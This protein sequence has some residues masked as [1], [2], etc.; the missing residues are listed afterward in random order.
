MD[1]QRLDRWL[2]PQAQPHVQQ[3][4]AAIARA[5]ERWHDLVAQYDLMKREASG[6]AREALASLRRE[7]RSAAREL[8]VVQASWERLVQRPARAAALLGV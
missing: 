8:R 2:P 6:H 1:A 4:R 5:A 3:L 7:M